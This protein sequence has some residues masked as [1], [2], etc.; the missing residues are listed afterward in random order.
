MTTILKYR[1]QVLPL[2][3]VL[4]PCKAL[5]RPYFPAFL[6]AHALFRNMDAFPV[7]P[8]KVNAGALGL[9]GLLLDKTA[10]NVYYLTYS[11]NLFI[12]DPHEWRQW[13]TEWQ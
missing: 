7:L 8:Q 12:D 11:M 5:D 3:P 4:Q 6:P 1:P 9:P 2:L 10:G 13:R